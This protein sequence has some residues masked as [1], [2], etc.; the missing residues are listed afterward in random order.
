MTLQE[1]R[2]IIQAAIDG[3]PLQYRRKQGGGKWF[4]VPS[5][6]THNFT[7][8]EME[9]RVKPEPREWWL[10]PADTVDGFIV[11]RNLG[12]PIPTTVEVRGKPILV[13]E[14]LD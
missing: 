5:I 1:Q 7:F 13:R 11:L 10:T 6:T 3:K 8:Y 12:D 14:V 4:D 2:D 9:Y